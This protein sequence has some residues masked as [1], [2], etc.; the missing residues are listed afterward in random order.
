M[1]EGPT[2]APV[3]RRHCQGILAHQGEHLKALFIALVALAVIPTASPAASATPQPSKWAY[4]VTKDSMND[5][6]RTVARTQSSTRLILNFP[7]QGGTVGTL[8]ITH[9]TEGVDDVYL[10]INRGQLIK[11]EGLTFRVDDGPSISFETVGSSDGSSQH[12][13][14][15]GKGSIW[16]VDKSAPQLDVVTRTELVKMIASAKRLRVR[17]TLYDAGSPVFEFSPAGLTFEQPVATPKSARGA[18]LGAK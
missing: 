1:R 16:P 2:G 12:L 3:G 13:W 14:L 18:L 17:A 5:G 8:A 11:S 10:S 6:V 7:Y 9:F 4:T 15:S